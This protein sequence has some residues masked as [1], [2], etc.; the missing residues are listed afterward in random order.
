MITDESKFL[1]YIVLCAIISVLFIGSFICTVYTSTVLDSWKVVQGSTKLDGFTKFEVACV[2]ANLFLIGSLMLVFGSLMMLSYKPENKKLIAG[3][4]LGAFMGMFMLVIICT[5]YPLARIKDWYTKQTSLQF[6]DKLLH[7]VI[8]SLGG[9]IG[10]FVMMTG[11][12]ALLY[13]YVIVTK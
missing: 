6:T 4:S 13:I 11:A 5:G 9:A 10:L 7:R 3:I 8:Y 1:V 2:F 12:V